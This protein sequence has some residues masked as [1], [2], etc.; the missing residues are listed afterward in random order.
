MH[1]DAS[2]FGPAL[3]RLAGL[4]ALGLV[5]LMGASDGQARLHPYYVV[6]GASFGQISPRILFVLDTSGSMA[7]RG[8]VTR[9]KC[10]H[11]Q[12]ETALGTSQASRIAT[13]R[14]AIKQVVTE[15]ADQAK[16]AFMTFDQ[17]R[18]PTSVPDKCSVKIRR[19]SCGSCGWNNYDTENWRFFWV[20]EYDSPSIS[21]DTDDLEHFSGYDGAYVL[22][23]DRTNRGY[24][25][26]RW[27]DVGKNP[28]S[29]VAV[30]NPSDPVP[31]SPLISTAEAD[32]K[33]NWGN[34]AHNY[35]RKVQ[36]FDRFM[37]VRFH[38][39]CSNPALEQVS[40]DSIG[41]W[42]SNLS[43]TDAN[44]CGNTFY[45]WPYVDGFPDY[46]HIRGRAPDYT[47]PLNYSS[48]GYE[49]GWR[50]NVSGQF[51]DDMGV[52]ESGNDDAA[53][54]SPFYLEL[55]PAEVDPDDWGP[56]D[57]AESDTT[58]LAH[59][60]TMIEGGVD[61]DGGTEWT[62]VVGAIPTSTLM[63]NSIFSHTTVSSYLE[64]VQS[65]ETPDMCAPTSAV[66]ITDGEPECYKDNG[67]SSSAC[68]RLYGRLSDLRRDLDVPTYV[69]GFFVDNAVINDMACAAAGACTCSGA[70]CCT[71][72]CAGT[73]VK[74]W[75]TCQDPQD[76]NQTCS[77]LAGTPDELVSVLS[78]IVSGLL[79]TEVSSGPGSALNDFG[80]PNGNNQDDDASLQ[81]KVNAWTKWPDWEGH[82]VRE[83]CN[84]LDVY[85]MDEDGNTTE[86]APYCEVP[87]PEFQ[88]AEMEETFGPCPQ[89]RVWNAGECLQQTDWDD[90]RIYSTDANNA[91]YLISDGSGNASATFVAELTSLGLVSGGDAQAESDT[92]VEFIH[93]KDWPNGWKMPGLA[94][95]AP[96]VVRRVPE[97]DD[98]MVPSVPIRDP[99]CAGRFL[100]AT[101]NADIPS[102]LV[103]FSQ[104]AWDVS[105]KIQTP[106]PHFEYQE[107]V[108]LGD[109][110]GV[111]HAFQLNSG[112]ELWGYLPRFLLPS[113]KQQSDLG[114]AA[115]GQPDDLDAHIFG[116]SST[117][118]HGWVWDAAG[119]K[120]R[121]LGIIGLGAGGDEYM[122][123][124][125]TH[126]SPESTDGPFEVLW[127]TEDATLKADFDAV[128]GETWARPALTY[129]LD[130]DLLSD[131][132]TPHFVMG[133]G[134][135]PDP[136]DK[137][138]PQGQ[139]LMLVDALTGN[140]EDSATLPTLN[141]AVYEANMGAVVDPAVG[142]HCISRFWAEQQEAYIA[143]PAGRLF[144]WDLGRDTNHE[145]DSGSTWGASATEVLRFP[146]CQGTGNTCTISSGNKGDPF[147]YAPAVTA[148][149]RIDEAVSGNPLAA[150]DQFLIAL[151]SGSPYDDTLDWSSVNHDFHPSL[152]LL[153]DDHST[154]D[155]NEGFTIPSGAPKTAA[156]TDEN[157]MRTVISDIT[158]T[159]TFTPVTGQ[160]VSGGGSCS[161]GTYTETTTFSRRARPIRAP[162]IVVTGVR[163]DNNG[164]PGELLPQFEI[165]DIE[166]MIFEP[167]AGICDPR[168]FN[169]TTKEWVFDEGSTYVLTM[170][171]L[172]DDTK[173]F[174][175]QTGTDGA[176]DIPGLADGLHMTNGGEAEQVVSG[177]CQDGICGPAPGDDAPPPCDNND[178]DQ[179]S[180]QEASVPISRTEVVGFDPVE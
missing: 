111:I 144:R 63:D 95:A 79:T 32:F 71:D 14:A 103:E 47:S 6:K 163:E 110:L 39:D 20:D 132:P 4:L 27:D 12:C 65:V 9:E 13:A 78:N 10:V 164:T 123:L 105:L 16:F 158:R 83:T 1:I 50:D 126:M 148:L 170:R 51:T 91:V 179:V 86:L 143:D 34:N 15:T 152:Y 18:P 93:G 68:A 99:H 80:L 36:W 135:Q 180:A 155:K 165:V 171:L 113:A 92:I 140:I 58:V 156:G 59:V 174:Q 114:A 62:T 46:S 139:S 100:S 172:V 112:N 128:L 108:V 107:A 147:I 161:N 2:R 44:V 109:D 84:E 38:V 30:N 60:S 176:I 127:T 116:V 41:D 151:A 178:P 85:D 3:T 145:S 102:K 21:N 22:C 70:T 121:H 52:A 133:S 90:R 29:G 75:D 160:C 49:Y 120:F 142:S 73:S 168:F 119:D 69:V 72:P 5:L 131:L 28:K 137:N 122:V 56:A 8:Q 175:F 82:L 40:D 54:Y 25:Y 130:N 33:P 88:V 125:L 26:L 31:A 141:T 157:F 118:N 101:Q 166:F 45:Y 177:G 37:G 115:V 146:A 96:V 87:D 57:E 76:H 66:L 43:G 24:P 154:G 104:N 167:G 124:D 42:G 19:R 7:W 97:H 53:L 61:A 67:N 77:Y 169:E 117:F 173:G 89:S 81:T 94:N 150:Q 136:F 23:D 98:N 159:R 74:S 106:T 138:D 48:G 55:D 129:T 162:K 17:K 35:E 134:P 64:F 153:V 11:N 149:D